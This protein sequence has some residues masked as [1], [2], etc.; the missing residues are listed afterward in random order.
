MELEQLGQHCASFDCSALPALAK[1]MKPPTP[2]TPAPARM[3]GKRSDRPSWF[4]GTSAGGG[5]TGTGS[6]VGGGAFGGVAAGVERSDPVATAR[7]SGPAAGVARSGAV[8]GGGGACSV[9]TTRFVSPCLR[10]TVADADKFGAAVN[11]N[12]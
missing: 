12:V 6:A 10:V 3:P 7:R 9:A 5:A 4:V 2:T 11:E 1:A 8:A